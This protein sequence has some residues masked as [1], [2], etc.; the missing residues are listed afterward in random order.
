[1]QAD[2]VQVPDMPEILL[3]QVKTMH[4]MIMVILTEMN[5]S[6]EN[7]GTMVL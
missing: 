2:I 6:V 7:M 5:I 1:M 3:H 4:D